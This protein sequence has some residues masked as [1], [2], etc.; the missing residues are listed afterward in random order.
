MSRRRVQQN[1]GARKIEPLAREK[2]P[3]E[4]RAAHPDD[5]PAVLLR[6][7]LIGSLLGGLIGY[8]KFGDQPMM[9]PLIFEYGLV[10][11]SLAFAVHNY[12]RFRRRI[13]AQIQYDVERSAAS[14]TIE[15]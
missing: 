1:P 6:R 14:G 3:I 7:I 5:R 4:L 12:L 2:S 13:L 11:G 15:A 8:L 10:M 9:R